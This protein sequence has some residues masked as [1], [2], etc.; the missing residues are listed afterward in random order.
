MFNKDILENYMNKK[1]LTKYR[2]A[3]KAGIGQSTLSEI[4]SGKKK[5]PSINT[6]QKIANALEIPLDYLTQTSA[7]SII[8]DKLK[9]LG[10][11]FEEL[12]NKTGISVSYLENLNNIT[13][14]ESDYQRIQLVAKSI[15]LEP[16][17]LLRALSIQEP[18]IYN[19]G[20]F[21]TEN[22]FSQLKEEVTLYETG[23]FKTPQEAMKFILEQPAIAAYGG[24][25]INEM[26]DDEIMDFANELLNQLKLLGYKYKK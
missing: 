6:L 1:G 26:S 21:D 13:P 17:E 20:K 11:T 10:V 16:S 2:L 22:D 25:D 18:P 24:F 14:D 4:M 3:K 9:E 7:K 5:N 12:S 19:W 15:G 23:K 8:K